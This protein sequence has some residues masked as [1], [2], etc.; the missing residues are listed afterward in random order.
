MAS[1]KFVIEKRQFVCELVVMFKNS[2]A[3]I[4]FA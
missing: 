3:V 2:D 4:I 1:E